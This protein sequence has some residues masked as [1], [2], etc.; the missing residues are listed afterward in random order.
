MKRLVAVT[1]LATA[2]LATASPALAAQA[3]VEVEAPLTD[4]QE[5]PEGGESAPWWRLFIL[6]PVSAAAGVGATLARR[7][8]ERRGLGGT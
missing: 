7:E 1:A 5:E 3:P 8:L 2:M 6:V 4:F